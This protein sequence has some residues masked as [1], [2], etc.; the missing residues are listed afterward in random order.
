MLDKTQRDR[1]RLHPEDQDH[2][3]IDRARRHL[4]G[5]SDALTRLDEKQRGRPAAREQRPA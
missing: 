2:E 3:L 1:L 5:L 4:K